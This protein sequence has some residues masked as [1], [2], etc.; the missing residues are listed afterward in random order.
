MALTKKVM[1]HGAGHLGK[2]TKARKSYLLCNCD[3]TFSNFFFSLGILSTRY[4]FTLTCTE[5]CGPRTECAGV[6]V[7]EQR[8][9]RFADQMNDFTSYGGASSSDMHFQ[10]RLRVALVTWYYCFYWMGLFRQNGLS[11][12][13]ESWLWSLKEIL[14]Q[15]STLIA[16]KSYSVDDLQT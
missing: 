7:K 5:R 12:E 9:S 1:T 15:V 11:S 8:S 2:E 13:A 14:A 16:S 3:R 10:A 6:P 4:W